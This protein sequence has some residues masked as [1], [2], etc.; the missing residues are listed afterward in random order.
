[1]SFFNPVKSQNPRV[2]Q[3]FLYYNREVV[4]QE[5]LES[6]INTFLKLANSFLTELLYDNEGVTFQFSFFGYYQGVINKTLEYSTPPQTLNND[7]IDRLT[8]NTKNTTKLI[9]KIITIP[10]NITNTNYTITFLNKIYI[11][12]IDYKEIENVKDNLFKLTN[13]SFNLAIA[14][15]QYINEK[16]SSKYMA[17]TQTTDAQLLQVMRAKKLDEI[18]AD[19]LPNLRTFLKRLLKKKEG[20]IKV[21]INYSAIFL[22]ALSQDEQKNYIRI[23]SYVSDTLGVIT[24]SNIENRL[25]D[26]VLHAGMITQANTE[27]SGF[28][29]EYLRTIHVSIAYI[30]ALQGSSYLELPKQINNKKCCI[31]PQNKDQ[32]CFY[33]AV[34]LGMIYN[35]N[36][37]LPKDPQRVTTIKKQLNKDNIE[38]KDDMLHYP[39]EINKSIDEFE[40]INNVSINIFGLCNESQNYKLQLLRKTNNNK[41]DE[42]QINLL[43][44]GN[45]QNDKSKKQQ[46]YLECNY[47]YVYIKNITR[48]FADDKQTNYKN[49][50]NICY[51]CM[52]K[53]NQESKYL[54]HKKN[55]CIC[56]KDFA[57]VQIPKDKI[58]RF[59]NWH[60]LVKLPCYLVG[61]FESI[62]V[63]INE[64]KGD[65]T[66]LTQKHIACSYCIKL[67]SN[68]PSIEEEFILFRGTSQDEVL[69]H[70]CDSIIRLS[71]KVYKEYKKN[72][73]M[74]ITKQ[75][76]EDFNYSNECYICSSEFQNERNKHRD[77]D[78]ITGKY[79][80]AACAKCNLNRRLKDFI[81]PLIF[82]N[83]KGYD[84]KYIISE[85]SKKKYNCLISGIPMSR[86]AFLSITIEK[87]KNYEIKIEDKV[88][89]KSKK[90]MCPIRII[91]SLQFFSTSLNNLTES[92]KSANK[93]YKQSFP[94]M[95]KE[96]S[97]IYTEEQINLILRKNICP[98]S[99]FTD[100]NKFNNKCEWTKE[101]FKESNTEPDFDEKYKTYQQVLKKFNI[102]TCGEYYD[103]YLK[104]DVLE[105]ADFI[106]KSRDNLFHTHKL[107][108]LWYYGAPG[109]SWNA[110]LYHSK[111]KLELLD[112]IDMI[113]FFS[114]ATRG[115]QSFISKRLC[116]ANNKYMANYDKT[117]ESIF[118]EYLDMNNLYGWSMQQTLPYSNFKWLTDEEIKQIP[119]DT[120]QFIKY[121]NQKNNVGYSFEVDLE[122]PHELHDL[123]NDYPLAPEKMTIKKEWLSEYTLDIK[124][125]FN[126]K[127]DEKTPL[128]IQTLAD[129]N[130]YKV[131]Y[132]VLQLYLELGMKI[133]KINRV[134]RYFQKPFMKD[135]IDLNTRLRNE[136]IKTIEGKEE[137]KPEFLRNLYK[138]MNNSIY[139][140]TFENVFNY[141]NLK[142]VQNEKKMR[143]CA[144][145]Y[146][147]KASYIINED[148]VLVDMK[149]ETVL[150][151]KPSYL[152]S[153]ITDLAK[154]CMYN[155][156]Y[157]VMLKEIGAENVKVFFSDTDSL[158]YELKIEDLHK[159]YADNKWVERGL[160]DTSKFDKNH[161]LYS[162]KNTNIGIMKSEIGNQLMKRFIGLR[163]KMY[164]YETEKYNSKKA[165]G[166]NKRALK[167]ISINDYKEC[168]T[169]LNKSRQ[170]VNMSSIR[171]VG[172]QLYT[173]DINKIGL[174]ADDTKRYV[175]NDCIN[176]LAFGHY[177][178]DK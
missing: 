85:I 34:A 112:D 172:H 178:L 53:F 133:K 47:H 100:F 124:D 4:T 27:Q 9:E 147:Y 148:F 177:N 140:K 103:L 159:F 18:I 59:K 165:K 150:C 82:H 48:F 90:M 11:S 81:L 1:M 164:C 40:Q 120:K 174:S 21:T 7:S 155:F 161:P 129:K 173:M 22:K 16:I 57:N 175:L 78:H 138:L 30:D 171:S 66:H 105:L 56:E 89:T 132:K 94:I 67:V 111:I 29:F 151:N 24:L 143:K 65:N 92:L 32:K 158:G 15:Y 20:N 5:N 169:D 141:S 72:V 54:N 3:Q 163:S 79:L 26:I 170:E 97:K 71:E 109:F 110:F 6:H 28:Y 52:T 115:G 130:N 74:V 118:L 87:Y 119:T 167:N 117:K 91:D 106:E 8:N 80:G 128:L 168:L 12:L 51:E 123:H 157:N 134:V 45:I 50:F 46:G 17:E 10:D 160:L 156:H 49:Y 58:V 135:Y 76:Q 104:C 43:L 36:K 107:D 23:I 19:F 176:T 64:N 153:V 142:M 127:V 44:I 113:K 86:E 63:P 121:I 38:I 146:L 136:K 14:E 25:E 122:Y 39:V 126:Q 33:Y 31:N 83:A 131:H 84:M 69:N 35:K 114:D 139:G 93:D 154:Y 75:Q 162:L 166:I 77:H 55:G 95:F 62:L 60:H 145:S 96:F 137:S 152:G 99:Y 13:F 61:D 2:I 149:K 98:Y 108:L 125:K 68:H 42:E 102:N 144:S 101:D 41:P 73:P 37:N 88:I 116:N 70:F